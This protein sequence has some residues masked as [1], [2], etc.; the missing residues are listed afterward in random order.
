MLGRRVHVRDTKVRNAGIVCLLR[1][2]IFAVGGV[3]LIFFILKGLPYASYALGC[4]Q[5]VHP[6]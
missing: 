1:A 3:D 6:P 5:C 2:S 4:G